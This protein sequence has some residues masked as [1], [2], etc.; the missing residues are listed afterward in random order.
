MMIKNEGKMEKEMKIEY[1]NPIRNAFPQLS[2]RANL[3]DICSRRE[4]FLN[5]HMNLPLSF[6]R[7]IHL[8]R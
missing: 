5:C 6:I 3:L 8:I 1:L 7:I 2:D 4:I